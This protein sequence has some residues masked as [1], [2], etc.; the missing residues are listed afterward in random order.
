MEWILHTMKA[1]L[2]AAEQIF[3]PNLREAHLFIEIGIA[4]PITL[5]E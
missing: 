4:F 1:R 5:I 3:R 2:T